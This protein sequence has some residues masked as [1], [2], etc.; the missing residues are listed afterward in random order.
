MTKLTE[1]P[2]NVSK[3]LFWVKNRGFGVKEW[4]L[5]PMTYHK[6]LH[7][8]FCVKSVFIKSISNDEWE[9]QVIAINFVDILKNNPIRCNPTKQ[10]SLKGFFF[11]FVRILRWKREQGCHLAFLILFARYKMAL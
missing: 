1:M 3:T 6:F 11:N 4:G 7:L 9:H 2:K 5:R 10:S 8:L